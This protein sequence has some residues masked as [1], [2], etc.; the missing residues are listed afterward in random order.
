MD[1]S[2]KRLTYILQDSSVFYPHKEKLHNYIRLQTFLTMR[3]SNPLVSFVA[4]IA[5]VSSVTASA[6][7]VRRGDGGGPTTVQNCNG[8]SLQCCQ[9]SIPF[10][11]APENIFSGLL[12]VLD[13]VT[14]ANVPIG[15]SCVLAGVD[16]WYCTPR[17]S[18]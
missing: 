10:I 18:Y 2:Y 8:G 1:E 14:D 6:T 16:G 3:F 13:P 17:F 12:S 15:L 4:T 9:S 7:P 5:L 11:D